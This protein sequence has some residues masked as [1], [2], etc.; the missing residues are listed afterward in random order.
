MPAQFL[1]HRPPRSRHVRVLA[2]LG[3]ASSTAAEIRALYEAGADAFRVNMSHGDDASKVALIDTVRSLEAEIG[4]P[5]T[6][7]ADLQGPKL[8]VGR[9]EDG[10][11]ELAAGQRFRLDAD[12]APGTA[13]RVQLPLP[14]PLHPRRRHRHRDRRHCP[15][16]SRR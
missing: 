7:L 4:R 12:P 10:R 15:L 2:T 8:R 11:V 9:F 6:I 14:P 1:S 3:P 5:M 13:R 16:P